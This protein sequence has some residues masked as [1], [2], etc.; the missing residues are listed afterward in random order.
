MTLTRVD[1]FDPASAT[2]R[3]TMGMRDALESAVLAELMRAS[4]RA[5]RRI[6]VSVVR[7]ERRDIERELSVGT[8][9]VAL[10]VLLPLPEE[11]SPAARSASNG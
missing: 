4:P 2:K 11:I 3:F 1:R 8:L 9:D 7:T 5:R 10:D 6:D